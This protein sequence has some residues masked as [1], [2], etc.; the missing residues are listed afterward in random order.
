[1]SKPWSELADRMAELKDLSSVI[2]LLSWDQET[3]MPAKA[4]ASR[5]E[6]LATLQAIQHER[7]TAPRLGELLATVEGDASLDA[8]QKASV[9]NLTF[10]RDRAIKLPV[11]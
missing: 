11:S 4:T 2:G 3:V 9:R 5:A 8:V 1:M 6:Q 7:L 10:E